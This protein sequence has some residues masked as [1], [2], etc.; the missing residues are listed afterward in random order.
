MPTRPLA[1]MFALPLAQAPAMVAPPSAL[2]AEVATER[3]ESIALDAS[4][5][6]GVVTTRAIALGGATTRY[7]FG[8][9]RCRGHR[10]DTAM[11]EQ[12][13]AALRGRQGVRMTADAIRGEETSACLVRVTFF[14]PEA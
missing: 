2:D 9:G 14:A 3:I 8:P 6:G 5:K 1:L 12:M 10:I 4:G 7:A 13:F 11:L